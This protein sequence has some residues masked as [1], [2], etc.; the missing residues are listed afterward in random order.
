[1]I[2]L[3]L[4]RR[5]SMNED[6]V[7]ACLMDALRYSSISVAQS[8]LS[9]ARAWVTGRSLPAFDS[10]KIDPWPTVGG[11]EPDA[12]IL[13]YRDGT[14]ICRLL[15]EAKIGAQ[16]TGEG[17]VDRGRHTGDQLAYYATAEAQEHPGE[18]VSMLYLTHHAACPREDL[19]RS[20]EVI[21][22]AGRDELADE[23]FW[24][25]WRDVEGELQRTT[26][27]PVCQDVA[28]V[29]RAIRMYRFRGFELTPLHALGSPSFYSG[30][31][32][33]GEYVDVGSSLGASL[34]SAWFYDRRYLPAALPLGLTTTGEFYGG[35]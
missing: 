15:L 14:I 30:R 31:T 16:K 3:A 25:S 26:A 11:R 10:I 4:R 27:S 5:I 29:L 24:L 22:V 7:T 6:A 12:R 20:S 1:M 2:T 33:H 28:E 18:R 19:E 13:L 17:V 9:G 34:G 35:L 32:R 21:R 8:V 23:L